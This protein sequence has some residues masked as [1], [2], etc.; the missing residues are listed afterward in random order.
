[1]ENNKT[2]SPC[3]TCASKLICDGIDG[4][5]KEFDSWVWPELKS[6]AASIMAAEKES[7]RES[8]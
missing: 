3:I 2:V 6:V 4:W 5:C 8:L 7:S 1:M